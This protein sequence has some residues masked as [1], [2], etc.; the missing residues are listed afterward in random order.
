MLDDS[1]SALEYVS[2]VM[3]NDPQ[4]N[5]KNY[6]T[7]KSPEYLKKQTPVDR[8]YIYAQ[9]VEDLVSKGESFDLKYL[10][11]FFAHYFYLWQ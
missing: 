5:F 8:I 1:G 6:R 11:D 2:Y 4:G 9:S 10:V 3:I 7:D